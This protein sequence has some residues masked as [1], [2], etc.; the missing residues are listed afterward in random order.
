[1][2][3]SIDI[4][5][6]MLRFREAVRHNWNTYFFDADDV[7]SP[8]I[9]AA[10][11]HVEQGLFHGVVLYACNI[12]QTDANYGSKLAAITVTPRPAHLGQIFLQ[13]GTRSET[14][15]AWESPACFE[16]NKDSRFEFVRFFDW[17]PYEQISLSL[18]EVE[19]VHWDGAQ[20][21]VGCRALAEVDN[22]SFLIEE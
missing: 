13:I 9:S 7:M 3:K 15:M 10:F 2:K 5:Q 16:V 4:T 11:W 12:A 6:H 22:V 19:V 17:N 14:G 21:I 8:D 20:N 1:M 18:V